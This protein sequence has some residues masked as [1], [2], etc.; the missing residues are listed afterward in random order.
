MPKGRYTI[1]AKGTYGCK[2]YPVV[3]ESGRVLGCHTTREAALAQLRAIYA[4]ENK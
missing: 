1:G 3:S 4:S 2:G